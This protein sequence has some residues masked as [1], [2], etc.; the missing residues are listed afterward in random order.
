MTH[1]HTLNPRKATLKTLYDD[2]DHP[3][4]EAIVIY[5][6]APFSFTGEDIVEFQCHGGTIVAS[7]VLE[8]IIELGARLAEPGE[9]TKR[10]LL[11]GKM[12]M[13]KAEAI[14]SLINAKSEDA[15]KLLSRQLKGALHD[16]VESIRT[17]LVEILAYIEVTI[18]YAEEDLPGDLYEQITQKLESIKEELEKTVE[19]SR[20]R[21]GL[22]EGFQIAIVGKPNVGK[23]SLLNAL[24][25]YNRAITSDIA[26]TTRDTIEESLKIG[27]HL[28]RIIDTAGIRESGETIEKIGIERAIASAES[29]DVVIALFD[30]SA[31]IDKDDFR[32]IDLL[33]KQKGQKR[34]I[35][36]LN[37]KDLPPKFDLKQLS[38]FDPIPISVKEDTSV[39]IEK[40]RDYLDLQSRSHDMILINKRQ[41]HQVS[42]A[43]EAISR[44]QSVLAEGEFELFAYELND[45]IEAMAAITTPFER[46]EILDQMF[47]S[48]CL[49]K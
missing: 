43:A 35:V 49:G 38:D 46:E 47:G 9:F 32:I 42:K 19:A 25:H 39:L 31:P 2:N 36:L 16:Y 29:A 10:A 45:A 12:D 13:T 37:K 34:I 28:V 11:N 21:E 4:D 26:G 22:I 14:A 18:D 48:F 15:A 23:S 24:L 17:K 3:L 8:R 30:Q 6:K 20:S 40:L 41:I 44:A 7:M 1:A 33:Q 5:F 27:T